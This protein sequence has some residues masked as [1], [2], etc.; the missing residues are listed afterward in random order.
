MKG[1]RRDNPG[2]F[3]IEIMEGK[4]KY[5]TQAT[6]LRRAMLEEKQKLRGSREKKKPY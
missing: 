6:E 2:G 1:L 4:I 5:I 3:R